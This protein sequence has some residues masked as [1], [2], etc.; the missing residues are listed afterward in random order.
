MKIE[1]IQDILPLVE[2]PSRYLGTEINRTQKKPDTAGLRFALA[3]PDMYEIGMS[4]F[5]IQILYRIL[6]SHKEIVAER[7]FVPGVD[8][9]AYLRSSNIP[10]T[11]LE[12]AIPLID[13]DII[14]FSL[15]Y[16]LNYTNILT[17]LD[18]ASI[19]FFASQRDGSYPFVIAG[20]PCTCNPEPVADFFDAMVIGDGEE[21]IMKMADTW[22]D[23]KKN[24]KGE[25]KTLLSV[26]SGIEGVYIPSFFEPNIDRFGFQT[27]SPERSGYKAITRA[28]VND[29]DKAAFPD[30]P[31]LPYAKPVHDRLRLEISRGCT[32]GCR[33]CQAGIIYRPGRERS[34]E[35]LLALTDVSVAATGYGDI[36]LL[37]LSA[38]DYGGIVDLMEQLMVQCEPNHIAV[39][40]PSLRA[41]TLT[42]R[43]MQLIKRVR[44]TGFTIAPEAGTQRL[45]DI[46]NKN[47]TEKDISDTVEEAFRLGWQVIK[48]YFMVGLPAETEDDIRAIVDLV[49]NLRKSLRTK[50]R[51]GKINVSVATF[52]PKPHTPFQWASQCS[53]EESEKKIQWLRKNLKIPGVHFKWQSPEVSFIEGLWARGDRRLSRL[54]VAAYERGCKLDGWSDKFQYRLW[55]A[56]ISDV[57]LD[58]DFFTTRKRILNESL[59]WDHIDTRIEKEFL[60]REWEKAFQE[61]ITGDCRGGECNS[62]GVC[63]FEV[64]APKIFET[65][66]EIKLRK[67]KTVAN[68]DRFYRRLKVFYSKTDQ[69]RYFGH[70][71]LVNIFIRALRRAGIPIKY[72]EG[73]HPMPKVSF[74]DPLPVGM[75]SLD[76]IFYI[77]VPADVKPEAIVKGLNDQL[78]DGLAIHACESAPSKASVKEATSAAY[79]VKMKD[80]CFEEKELERFIQKKVLL[81][82]R[83]NRKGRLKKINLKDMVLRIKLIDKDK[84]KITLRSETGKTIR[85]GEVVREIFNL[86]DEDVKQARVIKIGKEGGL[87]V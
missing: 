5:G 52:I 79:L 28:I 43:L 23:G 34:M 20:G 73:F 64:V 63:D 76:E 17:L 31:I 72:S 30:A 3:F 53:L 14:G 24:G 49:K 38:G 57:N 44:K 26:W 75:E 37:S 1:T 41:G 15:L 70:L 33:F 85:P 55:K 22:L 50:A 87:P 74:E 27:L 58:I 47:I 62:C 78:P 80:G 6:N 68:L 29:L 48:L 84:L 16:E 35:T 46:I 56:A 60:K 67:E 82:T 59:P 69:A 10:I 9:E 2:Q 39:S 4:H 45:R 32:R 8:M 42:P 19:P 71:E 65:A 36:S 61:E 83:R 11:T 86:P 77:T 40:F 66:K 18:L 54:L 51:R 7:V 21:V 13:V 25:K 12:S 81:Y